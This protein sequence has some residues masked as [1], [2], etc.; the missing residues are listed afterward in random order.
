MSTIK[1]ANFSA[2]TSGIHPY[3]LGMD[4]IRR[5]K[6]LSSPSLKPNDYAILLA[7]IAEHAI[8]K[9]EIKKPKKKITYR[10]IDSEWEPTKNE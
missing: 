1:P 3:H 10:S 8:L 4:A 9:H 2:S 5:V 6:I 7:D